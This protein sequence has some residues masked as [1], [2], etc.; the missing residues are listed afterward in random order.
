MQSSNFSVSVF[1]VLAGTAAV[2]MVPL[3]AMQFTSEVN[4]SAFDFLAMGLL[5]V[6]SGLAYLR[7][8]RASHNLLFKLA[9]VAAVGSVFLMVWANLAVGLIGSG[10]HA[11]NLM[12]LAVVAVAIA[13]GYFSRFTPRGLARTMF[14][15]ALAVVG[16]AV[17]SLAIGL[18]HQPSI[19]V[20]EIVGVNA[21]FAALFCIAGVMFWIAGRLRRPR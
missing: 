4:W 8:A 21:S 10:P 3:I 2:L 16:V 1:Y 14:A 6:G 18:Q 5:L 11:G 15:T 13:G 20:D 9:A 7:L 12:Y 17:V 19:S